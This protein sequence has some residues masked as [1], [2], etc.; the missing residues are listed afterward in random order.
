MRKAEYRIA[1]KDDK[2]AEA[3]LN[4]IDIYLMELEHKHPEL[5]VSV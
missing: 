1:I 5:E 4:E 2:K 3:I